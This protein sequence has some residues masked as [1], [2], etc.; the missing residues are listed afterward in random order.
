MHIKQATE[1]LFDWVVVATGHFCHPYMPDIKG[2]ETFTGHRVHSKNVRSFGQFR[3][4]RVL[5]VG[6]GYSGIDMAIQMYKFGAQSVHISYKDSPIDFN[7]SQAEGCEIKEVPQVIEVRGKTVTLVDGTEGEYDWIIFCTG[8]CHSFPFMEKSLSL[9]TLGNE[10]YPKSLYKGVVMT[11]NN[12]LFYM[13][14]QNLVYSFPLYDMQAKLIVECVS[15]GLEAPN[16]CD[17]EMDVNKWV[18]R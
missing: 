15:G 13:G 12:K 14:M 17:M 1:E 7:W 10:L 6:A 2:L 16:M 9:V 8:Y 11:S 5:C 18:E 3:G 4:M